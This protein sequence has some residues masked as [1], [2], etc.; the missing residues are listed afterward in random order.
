MKLIDKM[1][2]ETLGRAILY[3]FAVGFGRDVPIA[4]FNYVFPFLYHD[5]YRNEMLSYSDFKI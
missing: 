4:Y 5:L 3:N 1:K 2:D